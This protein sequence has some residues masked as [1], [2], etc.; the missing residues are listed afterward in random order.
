MKEILRIYGGYFKSQNKIGD[1]KFSSPRVTDCYEIEF[2]DAD[3]FYTV[4]DGEKYPLKQNTLIISKPNQERYSKLHFNCRYFHVYLS[5]G[6]IKDFFDNCK[7]LYLVSDGKEYIKLF[8][9]LSRL[10]VSAGR[11]YYKIKSELYALIDRLTKDA[12][13]TSQSSNPKASV[14]RNAVIKSAKYIEENFAFDIK[15]EDIAKSVYL[16][17]NYF[18]KLFKKYL[19]VSPTKY[20]LEVRIE[21]AK[22]LLMTTELSI[23]EIADKCGFASQTYFSYVFKNSVGKSPTEYL[24]YYQKNL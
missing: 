24:L 8:D 12:M 18:F 23:S 19:G 10:C 4:I 9:R 13:L 17:P 2:F 14:S 1:R 22:Y 16:H 15:L 3:Y 21:H 5:D 11:N 6:E 20:L 7:T